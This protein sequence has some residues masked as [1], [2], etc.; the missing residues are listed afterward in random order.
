MARGQGMGMEIPLHRECRGRISQSSNDNLQP[1]YAVEGVK[2]ASS[3]QQDGNL[4][5]NLAAYA[6]AN[7]PPPPRA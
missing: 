2:V 6:Q 4:T 1:P 7:R 5:H 3:N